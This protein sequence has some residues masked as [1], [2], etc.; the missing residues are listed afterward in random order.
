MAALSWSRLECFAAPF[1]CEALSCGSFWPFSWPEPPPTPTAAGMPSFPV[2][3]RSSQLGGQAFE[4]VPPQAETAASPG[5]TSVRVTSHPASSTQ[6]GPAAGT[7]EL[8]KD[9]CERRQAPRSE[10]AP[11]RTGAVDPP[12]VTEPAARRRSDLRCRASGAGSAGADSGQAFH[13]QDI[14]HGPPRS[15]SSILL[16]RPGKRNQ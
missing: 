11:I 8:E 3:A 12:S 7:E 10:P 1:R 6:A 9:C 14:E 13:Q 4:K 5:E 15:T 2:T 16:F